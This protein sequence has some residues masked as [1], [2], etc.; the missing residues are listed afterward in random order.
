[1]GLFENLKSEIIKDHNYL[2]ANEM[3]F[4]YTWICSGLVH[5]KYD[6]KRFHILW[7]GRRLCKLNGITQ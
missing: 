3:P 4:K 1:M 5:T 6:D 7:V 2:K